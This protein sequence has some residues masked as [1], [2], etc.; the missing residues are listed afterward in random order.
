ML[1]E[2][3]MLIILLSSAFCGGSPLIPIMIATVGAVIM[4][5]GKED[6]N[7]NNTDTER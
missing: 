7:G 3:G 5:V 6:H 1:Y 2:I 4:C